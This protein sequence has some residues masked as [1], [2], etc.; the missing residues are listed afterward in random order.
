MTSGPD[1]KDPTVETSGD[2]AHRVTRALIGALPI[3]SGTAL[4][5][6]NWLSTPPI[7]KR[8]LKWMI[9]VNE[10][11][12]DLQEKSDLNIER[13]REN[14]HF[15]SILLHASTIAMKNHQDEKI[16]SLK[17]ILLNSISTKS[18]SED[19]QFTFLN[20]ID[21]FTPTHLKILYDIHEGFCWSPLVSFRDYDVNLEFS[22]ILLRQY[23]DFKHQGDFVFQVI[24][25]LIS[26]NLLATFYVQISERLNNGE[27]IVFGYSEWKQAI[28]LKPGNFNNIDESRRIYLTLPTELG[29][30]FLNF[31]LST[32]ETDETH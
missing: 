4:E 7:E 13:L 8:K 15:I 3:L 16:N 21:E 18:I 24:K 22:R 30:D 26:K 9:K 20:L 32:E 17:N 27:F 6:F 28:R 5:I 1:E 2:K 12:A 11:I 10:A 25:D 14:E 31:I 23:E 19:I 29:I